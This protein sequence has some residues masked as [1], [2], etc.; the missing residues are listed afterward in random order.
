MSKK[1][2]RKKIL[3][4]LSFKTLIKCNNKIKCVYQHCKINLILRFN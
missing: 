1:K 4:V 2:K 3:F